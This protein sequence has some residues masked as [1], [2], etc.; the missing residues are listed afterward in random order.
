VIVTCPSCGHA[1]SFE[2]SQAYHAGFA[3]QGFLYNDAG[4]LTLVWSSFDSAYEAIVGS[5]HPWT[6]SPE[7]QHAFEALLPTTPLGDR[8][9]FANP[10]RCS[11]C[12]TPISQS[13]AR[14]NIYYLEYDGS[15]VLDGGPASRRLAAYLTKSPTAT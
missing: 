2:Q 3:N 1:N 9:R 5:L 10:A 11:V 15:I 12:T 7:Q 6:L 4:T 8:W 14:G 13:I